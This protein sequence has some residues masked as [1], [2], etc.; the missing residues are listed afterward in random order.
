M[1]PVPP[2]ALPQQAPPVGLPSPAGI[3]FDT[4]LVQPEG[5]TSLT[6]PRFTLADGR[7]AR[8]ANVTYVPQRYLEILNQNGLG[9]TSWV[10]TP[11]SLHPLSCL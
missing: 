2:P 6:V 5:G 9:A 10:T 7:S 4:V 11:P 3:T 8:R 1:Q